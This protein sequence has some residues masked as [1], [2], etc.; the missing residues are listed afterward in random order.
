MSG[1]GFSSERKTTEAS[2]DKTDF[3]VFLQRHQKK[4]VASSEGN[5]LE[6]FKKIFVC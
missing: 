3:L 6:G 5:G 1:V 2:K 4:Q